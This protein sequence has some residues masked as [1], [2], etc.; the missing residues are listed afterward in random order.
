VQLAGDPEE[1]RTVVATILAVVCISLSFVALL[2]G[3]M[4]I[5]AAPALVL[6]G[7]SWRRNHAG[8]PA[9]LRA[10]APSALL[11][12][13]LWPAMWLLIFA[14][15]GWK[16]LALVWLLAAGTWPSIRVAAYYWRERTARREV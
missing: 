15:G 1:A 2:A 11:L 5:F 4:L 10:V 14:F 6:A 13:A 7:W 16:L 9:E 3:W 8:M 12:G